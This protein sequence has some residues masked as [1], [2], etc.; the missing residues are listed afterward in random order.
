MLMNIEITTINIHVLNNAKCQYIMQSRYDRLI[1]SQKRIAII[2]EFNI[3][4]HSLENI[5]PR[6][7]KVLKKI[8]NC[9]I[10]STCIAKLH[11][12]LAKYQWKSAVTPNVTHLPWHFHQRL[13][14]HSN[15]RKWLIRR[16]FLRWLNIRSHL[17]NRTS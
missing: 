2:L 14:S 12:V 7:S 13:H 8:T 17:H 4:R 5:V 16:E 11:L 6:I 3:I 15:R 9:P 10:W 1:I